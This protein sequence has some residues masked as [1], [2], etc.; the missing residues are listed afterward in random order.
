MAPAP[1]LMCSILVVIFFNHKVRI[2]IQLKAMKSVEHDVEPD[3]KFQLI[4]VEVFGGE[5]VTRV[6]KDG[7]ERRLKFVF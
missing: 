2:F 3:W 4:L 6:N 5:R 1:T 7:E